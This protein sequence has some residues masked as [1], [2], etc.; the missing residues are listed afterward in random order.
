TK[1]SIRNVEGFFD[2]MPNDKYKIHYG[3]IFEYSDG[4]VRIT[5]PANPLI[6]T[7]AQSQTYVNETVRAIKAQYGEDIGGRVAE[8][9]QK[10]LVSARDTTGQV[11][12][13]SDEIL[14]SNK[15]VEISIYAGG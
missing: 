11:G 2:P 9:L 13:Y 4:S 8:S 7:E 5:I 3:E 1:I 10:G 12:N 14:V 15:G 6:Y